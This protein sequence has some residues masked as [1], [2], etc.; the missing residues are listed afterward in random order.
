VY[1]CERV[2]L[3]VRICGCA[4]LRER[5]RYVNVIGCFCLFK[6]ELTGEKRNET[7]QAPKEDK[8]KLENGNRKEEKERKERRTENEK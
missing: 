7:F 3:N 5:G 8:L 2:C 4:C 1:E 6:V